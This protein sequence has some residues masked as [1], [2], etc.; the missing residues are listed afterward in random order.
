MS[1][2]FCSIVFYISKVLIIVEKEGCVLS[3]KYNRVVMLLSILTVLIVG[4]QEAPQEVKD[5]VKHKEEIQNGD[6]TNIQQGND[7]QI[8]HGELEYDTIEHIFE[9]LD[10][11]SQKK[12]ENLVIK[13]NISIQKP[14]RCSYLR[15]RVI[16]GFDK[17]YKEL[18][19]YY[20]GEEYNEQYI[21]SGE[22]LDPPGPEYRNDKNEFIAGIGNQGFFMYR[23]W[24][25]SSLND[26]EEVEAFEIMNDYEDRSYSL[27]DG[28]MKISEAI[29]KSETFLKDWCEKSGDLSYMPRTITIYKKIG[30]EEYLYKVDFQKEYKCM[31]FFSLLTGDQNLDQKDRIMLDTTQ[32]YI[33]DHGNICGFFNQEIL[34]YIETIQEYDKI[35]SLDCALDLVSEILASYQIYEIKEITLEY[36]LKYGE[37]YQKINAGMEFEAKPYWVIYFDMTKDR[38]IFSMVDCATGDVT[39]VNKA[40]K[41]G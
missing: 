18:F 38:E 4:C 19:P 31:P 12:Y 26:Y 1:E 15:F 8:K 25:V 5:F 14:E 36:A 27:K 28:E 24:N 32:I 10:Q 33:E 21:E 17:N 22:D 40:P 11:I 30:A 34:E 13:K 7:V 29:K 3:K 9:T 20:I 35:I 6:K 16:E 2:C 23:K 37:N 41:E 39:F